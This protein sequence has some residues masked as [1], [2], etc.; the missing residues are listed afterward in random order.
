MS[1]AV[2]Q[3]TPPTV[4]EV[5]MTTGN[6]VVVPLVPAAPTVEVQFGGPPGP[7]GG[8]ASISSDAGNLI[9]ADSE[10]RLHVPTTAVQAVAAAQ[11][12]VLVYDFDALIQTNLGIDL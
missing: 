5:G 4:I 6:A 11:D 7:P 1:A 3:L 12:K 2:V 9:E 8:A 10:N